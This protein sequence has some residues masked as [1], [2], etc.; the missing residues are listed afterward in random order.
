MWLLLLPDLY[1]YISQH[2]I[3][4]LA[5]SIFVIIY[6]CAILKSNKYLFLFAPFFLFIP[7]YLYYIS[8]YQTNINEQILSIVLETDY[9]EAIAFIGNKLFI[10]L[11][12]WIIWCIGCLKLFYKNYKSPLIW[13]HRSRLWV[14]ITGTL[15][16]ILTYALN[17]NLDAQ[18]EEFLPI[19]KDSFLTEEKNPYIQD[20]KKTYPIGFF[21]SISDLIKEQKKINFSFEK[22]KKFKFNAKQNL[23]MTQKQIYILVIGETS[24]RKNWQLN[25]YTRKTNPLL[26]QQKNIVNFNN[27]LSISSATRTSIPMILTRKSAD[28]IYNYNFPEKSII[29]AFKEVGFKTYW[30]STQQKFGNFDTSTSVYAKEADQVIFL[31]KANYTDAGEHDNVMIPVLNKI[32]HSNEKKQFIVLHTLG[33]HYNYAHRYPKEYDIFRPSLNDLSKYSLQEV[34]YKQ[35]LV[36]SYDNSI[37]FT[38]HVLNGFIEILKQQ[39]DAESFLLYTSDHGEDLFDN[40]CEKSGH[41]LRTKHNFEI[42]SFAW[43]SDTYLK[44]NQQKIA[45]LNQNKDRKIN[46]TAIFPTLIQAAKIHIPEYTEEKSIISPFKDYPR[47]VLGGKNFDSAQYDKIC[48]EIK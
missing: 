8:I 43:Y 30:L 36:N 42:A 19:Q 41:G 3:K 17:L 23:N 28:Q 6:L 10:Y 38:D 45:I 32:I 40:G 1:L 9:Q 48:K 35:Q 37:L 4:V 27:M 31:N 46:Q 11:V 24:R 39:K 44:N 22:K 5:L 33:S 18:A 47:L 16:F 12:F 20:I 21:I 2:N 15:Y 29:S 7:V 14:L 34:K 26:S 13:N 25:G